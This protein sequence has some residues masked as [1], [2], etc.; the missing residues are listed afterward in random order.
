MSEQ[1]GAFHHS[2]RAMWMGLAAVLA[3]GAI[4]G[5]VLDQLHISSAERWSSSSARL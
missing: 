3:I 5:I 2:A 1:R 4:A